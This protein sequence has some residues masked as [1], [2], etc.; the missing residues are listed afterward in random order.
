MRHGA[1]HPA[2]VSR[3]PRMWVPQRKEGERAYKLGAGWR[4]E[5]GETNFPRTPFLLFLAN[6]FLRFQY[7]YIKIRNLTISSNNILF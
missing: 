5:A 4:Q 7:N 2:S 3:V 1:G 6:W